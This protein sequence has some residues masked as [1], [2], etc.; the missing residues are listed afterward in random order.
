MIIALTI[1][2]GTTSIAFA[3]VD[4]CAG[5]S[6]TMPFKEV[7]NAICDLQHQIDSQNARITALQLRSNLAAEWNFENNA[8]DSSGQLNKGTLYGATFVNAVFGKALSF[9]GIDNVV[10]ISNSPSLNFG[11]DASFTISLWIKP[12]PTSSGWLVD[13]RRNN[14]GVYAGYTIQYDNG[15]ALARI[16]DSSSNDVLVSS[17][18]SLNDGKVHHIVFVVDRLTNTEKLFVDNHLDSSANISSVGS[19]DTEFDLHIGGTQSP[20]TPVD[21]YSGIIDQVRIY[22]VALTPSQ[23]SPFT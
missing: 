7:W 12:S 8:L 6:N 18:S 2:V 23:I 3:H 15:V 22:D 13:H 21:F 10:S 9:N 4:V 19:I 20:N 14:D 17:T 11:T 16:R 1:I 5:S